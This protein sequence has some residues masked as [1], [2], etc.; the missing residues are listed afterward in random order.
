[1][2]QVYLEP[3]GGWRPDWEKGVLAAV[4][5]GCLLMSLLVGIIMA[6]WAEQRRLFGDVL[7]SNKQLEQTTSKLQEEKLRLDALLVR[8]YNLI[9]VLGKPH[10]RG[11]R[12]PDD[13]HSGSDGSTGDAPEGLTLGE[14]P[15]RLC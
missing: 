15:W 14:G 13:G 5:L 3:E 12:S 11:C 8:Q 7:D 2:W 4:V 10:R 9:A 6:S 1:M